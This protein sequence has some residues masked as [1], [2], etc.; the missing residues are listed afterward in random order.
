[1]KVQGDDFT[2]CPSISRSV[3][4]YRGLT[5]FVSKIFALLADLITLKYLSPFLYERIEY[6]L[7]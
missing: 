4:P 7:G 1:V 3:S 5:A 6:G 2:T